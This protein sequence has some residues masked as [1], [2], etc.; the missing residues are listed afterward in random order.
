MK[1]LFNLSFITIICCFSQLIF[2]QT[3]NTTTALPVDLDGGTNYA[4][5]ASPGTKAFNFTVSGVGILNG[6]NNQLA[7]INFTLSAT[8]G[9]NLRDV[10][11]YIKS[12]AG[13]CVQISTTMGTTTNYTVSPTN[14]ID[15]SFR[16][17]TSCFNKAPDYSAFPSTTAAINDGSG[18]FGF[19]STTGNIQTGFNGQNADGTWTIYFS[20]S[21]TSAPCVTSSEL[22][23]GDPSFSDETGNGDQCVSAISWDG[24]PLCSTSVGMSPSTNTPGVNSS[25]SFASQ[26]CEWNNSNDNTVWIE[27]TAT[28]T[29]VCVNI[30]G[31]T[32]NQQSIIVSDPNTDGDGNPC[33]GANGGRYWTIESCPRTGDDIYAAVTGTNRNH[34]HCFTA[35]IGETYYLVIDG[36]S[37]ATSPFYVTGVS[38]LPNILPVSLASFTE[39]CVDN[40]PHL[41]WTTATEYN[42]DYFTIERS[43]DAE[44][45]EKIGTVRANGNSTTASNYEWV[46]QN[47]LTNIAYYRLSQTD[48]D[49][50]TEKLKILASNCKSNV[51]IQVVPNPNNG[52]FAIYGLEEG[53]DISIVNN[54]GQNVYTAIATTNFMSVDLK[55]LNSGIYFV[56]LKNDSKAEIVKVQLNK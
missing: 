8:C 17:T 6:T 2:S 56:Q 10:L 7:Q 48:F 24:G 27:F 19:F 28:Q 47:P 22:I 29:D 42:N 30:S 13:T 25:N 34:T 37:G 12:P 26:P 32:D 41:S 40:Q 18:R 51:S 23:F 11:C 33:T 49:G 44:Q 39:S 46:D 15:Y 55:G 9:G 50:Q 21:A 31:I 54:L 52:D 3:F 5:C 1:S 35:T 38:G 53:D 16:N 36:N 20:E 4:S 45:W 14:Q 43:S